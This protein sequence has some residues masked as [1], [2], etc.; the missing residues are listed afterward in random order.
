MG[1][2]EVAV[3]LPRA[4]RASPCMRGCGD[5][6][7]R[8]HSRCAQQQRDTGID[9][10]ASYRLPRASRASQRMGGGGGGRKADFLR[11]PCRVGHLLLLS[12]QASFP[13]C[14]LSERQKIRSLRRARR[15][16]GG[17]RS[18]ASPPLICDSARNRTVHTGRTHRERT[19]PDGL[20]DRLG[21]GRKSR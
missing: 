9:A 10:G 14:C 12:V 8:D 20:H 15:T 13:T 21:E 6:A 4:R 5:E 2:E 7:S 11:L 16:R 1:L 17:S 19:R 18:P 3:F